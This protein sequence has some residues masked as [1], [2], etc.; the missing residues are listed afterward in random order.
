MGAAC[1][2]LRWDGLACSGACFLVQFDAG[3]LRGHR[4]P[5][6]QQRLQVSWHLIL[7]EVL[8]P[9]SVLCPVCLGVCKS[10]LASPLEPGTGDRGGLYRSIHVPEPQCRCNLHGLLS[11]DAA[12][13]RQP[14]SRSATSTPVLFS[15]GTCLVLIGRR[16][17]R[18]RA[19]LEHTHRHSRIDLAYDFARAVV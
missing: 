4:A 7:P 14:S 9:Q 11:M 3:V 19:R 17:R 13:R 6:G 10:V 12:L 5:S 8:A 2:W 1:E 16:Y 18:E 15:M